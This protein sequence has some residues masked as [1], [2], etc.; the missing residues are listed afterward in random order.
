LYNT[1]VSKSLH[2][3]E[4]KGKKSN[5]IVLYNFLLHRIR[6]IF[7]LYLALRTFFIAIMPNPAA[8]MEQILFVAT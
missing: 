1:A 7:I 5:K 4:I 8:A 6:C 3:L 2:N